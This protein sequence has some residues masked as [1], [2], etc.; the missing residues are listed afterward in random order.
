MNPRGLLQTALAF[1]PDYHA[2]F[3]D[4]FNKMP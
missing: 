1:G 3:A 2:P 4:N